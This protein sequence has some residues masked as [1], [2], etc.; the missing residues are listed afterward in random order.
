MK[1]FDSSTFNGVI[2]QQVWD[3]LVEEGRRRKVENSQNE[4]SSV[5]NLLGMSLTN[6]YIWKKHR[7]SGYRVDTECYYEKVMAVLQ[8][9]DPNSESFGDGEIYEEYKMELERDVST[10]RRWMNSAENKL[11]ELTEKKLKIDRMRFVA[12]FRKKA[13]SLGLEV[14]VK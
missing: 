6:A 11:R 8:S 10:Y 13:E 12:E 1:L 5:A 4:A 7:F 14:T 2:T 9:R 3:I